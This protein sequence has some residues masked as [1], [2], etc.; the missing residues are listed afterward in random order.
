MPVASST[1]RSQLVSTGKAGSCGTPA[2]R[3]AF[4]AAAISVPNQ[5]PLIGGLGGEEPL[6]VVLRL[7]HE[8]L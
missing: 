4:V 6:L 3:P 8:A 7:R 2:M 1:P 5:A